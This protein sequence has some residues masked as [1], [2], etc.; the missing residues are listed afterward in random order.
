MPH[1]LMIR[2]ELRKLYKIDG[3]YES[4]WKEVPVAEATGALPED[5]RCM[6]CHGAVRIHKQRIALGPRDHVEHRTKEDSEG[7]RGG[8]YFQGEPHRMSSRPVK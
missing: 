5:I 8:V 7:C 4:R 1:D 3:E 2:C 6:H